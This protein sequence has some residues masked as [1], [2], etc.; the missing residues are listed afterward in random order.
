LAVHGW[1]RSVARKT[2]PLAA[3]IGT[4]LMEATGLS[5]RALLRVRFPYGQG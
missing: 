3:P 4:A 2:F 1:R 5:K